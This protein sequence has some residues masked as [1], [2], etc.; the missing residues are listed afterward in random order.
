M[1]DPQTALREECGQ[2]ASRKSSTA[3]WLGV[4]FIVLFLLGTVAILYFS[5][6][7]LFEE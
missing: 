5:I 1:V 3:G 2:C 7:M 6:R 4:W